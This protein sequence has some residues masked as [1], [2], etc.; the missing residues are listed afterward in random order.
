MTPAEWAA[1]ADPEAMARF[2]GDRLSDRKWRLFHCACVR[3]IWHL[4]PDE[5]L[6]TAVATAERHADGRVDTR[7]YGAAVTN[8]NRGRGRRRAGW[9]AYVASRYVPGKASWDTPSILSD[10]RS[11]IARLP[12][13]E[14]PDL[15]SRVVTYRMSSSLEIHTDPAG[16]Q[17]VTSGPSEILDVTPRSM[18]L[19]AFVASE[20][21]VASGLLD[22]AE[23]SAQ[24]ALLRDVAGDPFRPPAAEL[25]W[26]TADVVAAARRVYDAAEFHRVRDV[27]AALVVA[28]CDD[29]ALLAHCFAATEHVRGCWAVDRVLGLT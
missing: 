1:S 17:H 20:R 7:A 21:E 3:R 15:C 28:G 19:P 16:H 18:P 24:S 27:G 6:R 23:Q 25:P 8:A 13:W 9:A 11:A 2:L 4:L 22:S 14:L 5:R 29:A 26:L 12:V 10:C